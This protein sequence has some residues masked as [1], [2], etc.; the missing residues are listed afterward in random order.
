MSR[1]NGD[2]ARFNRMRKQKIDRRAKQRIVSGN[3]S[4]QADPVGSR[5]QVKSREKLA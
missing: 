1:K 4:H 2:K 5:S 3:L